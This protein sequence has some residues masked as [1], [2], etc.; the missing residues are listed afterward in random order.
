MSTLPSAEATGSTV[1]THGSVALPDSE[2]ALS[3][4]G[5]QIPLAW[6]AGEAR[7]GCHSDSPAGVGLQ[8]RLS[9]GKGV[10][11]RRT[12]GVLASRSRSA[13]VGE[14]A[15][16]GD[17]VGTAAGSG[18]VG[19]AAGGSTVGTAGGAVTDA[20]AGRTTQTLGGAA[21]GPAERGFE[22]GC[23]FAPSQAERGFGALAAFAA[24]TVCRSLSFLSCAAASTFASAAFASP[25]SCFSIC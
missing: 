14:D 17:T 6:P 5:E 22:G 21:L 11:D 3:V 15:A 24:L 25:M 2:A 23:A 4:V 9:S 16:G 1:S 13:D 18:T 20:A 7:V 8:G 10:D 12:R 19:T